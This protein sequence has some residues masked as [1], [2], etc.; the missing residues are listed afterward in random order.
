MKNKWKVLL[1]SLIMLPM[2][3]FFPGCNCNCSCNKNNNDDSGVSNL[4]TY[5]VHFFTGTKESFNYL[6]QEVP[7][8]G[9]VKEPNPP[10]KSGYIF[11]G[12][13]EDQNCNQ[14][15]FVGYAWD[16][17]LDT[18]DHNMELFARWEKVKK[19]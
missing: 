14:E 1:I 12:W 13:Y 17:N 8:G 11:I 18:V 15:G 2:V 7:D 3:V 6:T 19:D 9:L 16:F 10:K 5:T 4:L